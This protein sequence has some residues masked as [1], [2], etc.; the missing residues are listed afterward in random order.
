ML[1]FEEIPHIYRWNDSI[2]PSVTQ[3]IGQWLKVGDQY[4]N[5]FSGAT[6][7]ARMFE[8]AGQ[9]GT[10]V[11]TMID[12]YLDDDL[13]TSNLTANQHWTL[14]HF[15]NW[16]AEMDVEVI[17]H[18]QRLYSKKYKY[19][20]TYDIKARIDDRLWIVDIKTGAYDM[21]GPQLA[22]YCQLDK[23]NDR[24]RATRHR[25]VLYLPKDGNYKFIE[26]TDR[27]DWSFFLSRLNTH[28]YMQGR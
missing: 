5:V 22:A 21:A 17:A 25:A 7:D 13:D 6:V 18:E 2:V 3:I 27:A 23:E 11:H 26:M 28:N 16:M 9:W 12:Y 1:T 15:K 8:D 4:V 19:A 14:G 10:S 20:G 24:S